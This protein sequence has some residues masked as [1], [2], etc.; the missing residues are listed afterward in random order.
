MNK[1]IFVLSLLFAFGMNVISQN[2]LCINYRDN[3]EKTT[4]KLDQIVSIKFKG[5][6]MIVNS[7]NAALSSYLISGIHTMNFHD[8]MNQ[9]SQVKNEKRMI[10]ISSNP[11]RNYIKLM[12]SE[13]MGR[14]GLLR[15]VDVNGL[16]V[17]EEQLTEISKLKVVSIDSKKIGKGVF[18]CQYLS[19]S[20]GQTLKIIIE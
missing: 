5:D 6:T 20:F 3:R 18:F 1:F 12:F 8:I 16:I 11:I 4:L 7:K 2:D 17:Y 19:D 13:D 10:L 15:I 14:R 9:I